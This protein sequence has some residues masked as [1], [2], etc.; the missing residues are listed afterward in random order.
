MLQSMFPF[1]KF[2][3][4]AFPMSHSSSL[5]RNSFSENIFLGFYEGLSDFVVQF[6]ENSLSG[7]QVIQMS[8]AEFHGFMSEFGTVSPFLG[9]VHVNFVSFVGFVTF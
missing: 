1:E 9:K 3:F 6:A 4:V 7:F 5:Q 8:Q 2:Q